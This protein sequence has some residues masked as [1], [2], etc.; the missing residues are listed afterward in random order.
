MTDQTTS[1]QRPP[2]LSVAAF[3]LLLDVYGAD[4]TRWP[5]NVRA[6]A[7]ELLAADARARLLLAEAAALEETL[8]RGLAVSA[9]SDSVQ[10]AVLAER[11]MAA[12]TGMPRLTGVPPVARAVVAPS[13]R[14]VMDSRASNE[15][16]RGAAM[17][18]A[19]LMIGVFVGQSQLGA[20]AL[21][22]L[23]AL[24]GVSL[25]GSL[26]RIAMVDLHLEANDVD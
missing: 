5:L 8:S 1:R 23:E 9:K 16:W 12:S 3:E 11:I 10:H 18:A 15:L 22:A 6:D 26:D 21:P 19:S 13:I 2:K 24:S 17:L 20:H 7:I 25:P 14:H 4:R